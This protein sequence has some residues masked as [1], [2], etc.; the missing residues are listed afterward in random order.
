MTAMNHLFAGLSASAHGN[1][2]A[3]YHE[4]F[5]NG[6]I[7]TP[8]D[9]EARGY[10]LTARFVVVNDL[11]KIFELLPVDR[12]RPARSSFLTFDIKSHGVIVNGTFHEHKAILKSPAPHAGPRRESRWR[13]KKQLEKSTSAPA[14]RPPKPPP[15]M[16]ASEDPR[17]FGRQP[18]TP[19]NSGLGER[20]REF[21]PG[22]P[23][24]IAGRSRPATASRRIFH[25]RRRARLR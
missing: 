13:G 20:R 16:F 10:R 24:A 5:Q 15:A 19:R 6:Q 23:A 9:I 17:Y 11:Y 1:P 18:V 3:A 8:L 14:A 12:S 21:N 25:R 2:G 7:I 22:C 4:L